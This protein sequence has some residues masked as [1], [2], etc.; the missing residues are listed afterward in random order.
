MPNSSRRTAGSGRAL[1]RG[2]AKPAP[3]RSEGEDAVPHV[4]VFQSP[5]GWIAIVL[6]GDTLI[7]LT[8]AHPT[9]AEA[10]K[11]VDAGL[12]KRRST[13]AAAVLISRLKRFASGKAVDFSDIEID[14]DGTTAFQ[15]RVIARCRSILPGTTMSYAEVAAAI[16]SPGAARAVGNCMAR[17]RF[18]LIV[19]CHR[20]VGAAGRLGGYSAAGGLETKTRLLEL[21]KPRGPAAPARKK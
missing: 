12:P 14:L 17:N 20:V 21:E 3:R 13:G 7:R 9:P 11:A 16:G 2:K 10:L 6:R 15:R 18:P 4:D 1:V 5:L 8:F 19:P